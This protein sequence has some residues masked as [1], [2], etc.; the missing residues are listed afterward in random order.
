MR[1][2][3]EHVEVDRRPVDRA[4]TADDA[5]RDRTIEA[6]ETA[7]RPVVEK[8]ARVKEEVVVRKTAEERTERV[9]DT[10]RRTEVEVED[11]RKAEAHRPAERNPR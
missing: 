8:E 9:T 7:E 10:V 11:A 2:R 1:L 3:E 5:F 6:T 4:A